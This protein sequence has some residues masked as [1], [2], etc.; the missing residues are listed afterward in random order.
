MYRG[1]MSYIRQTDQEFVSVKSN[2]RQI[3]NTFW[4]KR[5]K[6]DRLQTNL[7]L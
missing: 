6:F 7:G 5:L 3:R 1:E 2:Q 4:N